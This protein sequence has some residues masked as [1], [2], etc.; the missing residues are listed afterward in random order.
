MIKDELCHVFDIPDKDIICFYA[1]DQTEI[2]HNIP[3]G[4]MHECKVSPIIIKLVFGQNNQ[5][6]TYTDNFECAHAIRYRSY[7]GP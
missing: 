3:L 4:I 1:D 2:D 7:N 6:L 5:V